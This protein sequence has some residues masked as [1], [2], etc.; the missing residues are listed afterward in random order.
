MKI[1]N[2]FFTILLAV[3]FYSC[4]SNDSPLINSTLVTNVPSLLSPQNNSTIS[5]LEPAFDW[6]DISS[7]S[8]YWLQVSRNST[9]TDFI[10][11]LSG[12]TSSQYTPTGVILSDS[13][14]Y[15]WRVRGIGSS[16]TTQWSATFVFAT[17][18]ES[19]NPTNKILIEIF[20]NT[21][22]IP[23]VDANQYLDEIYNLQGI[24]SNDNSV[25][26]MRIHTTLFAGDPFYLYNTADNN[27]RMAFYPNAAIVNPRTFLL[28]I[29]MGNYSPAAW[30]NK[31]NEK[32]AETRAYAIKLIN[33]YDT[34]TR[35]GSVNIKIKQATGSVVNDL[36]YHVAV[37]E[38]E[39][40]YNAPNG[41]IHFNNTLRDLVTPSGGQSF[42][43]SLGQ[44]LRYD[45]NYVI[46]NVI[47]QHKTDLIVF[48]QRTS[49]KE[50]MAVEKI[51]LR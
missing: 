4:E 14:S 6:T 8:S 29:F 18:L 43:I 15:Y 50:V 32:L 34:V 44:T 7:A 16:D 1:K 35:S 38:N 21:S 19:I 47:R 31:I 11:D 48:V 24:S 2:I 33:T 42:N 20:T 17:S 10:L 5:T 30:T 39:I 12:L 36:V 22:C 9:F 49:T 45:Q 28:G 46:D 13:N 27:A 41:E 37:S 40:A 51:R 3:I 26:I 25:E 23:C